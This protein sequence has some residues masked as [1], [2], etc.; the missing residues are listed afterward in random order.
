MSVHRPIDLKSA[1]Q[2]PVNPALAYYTPATAAPAEV[3]FCPL[4]ALDQMYAYYGSDRI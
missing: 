3:K 4:S 2:I 1:S